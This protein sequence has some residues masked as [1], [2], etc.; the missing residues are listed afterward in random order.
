MN[1]LNSLSRLSFADPEKGDFQAVRAF[2]PGTGPAHS[3][4]AQEPRGTENANNEFSSYNDRIVI[5]A[6][7]QVNG[8][9]L[10][11]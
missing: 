10:S 7:F 9:S 8:L 11:H 6:E 3:L 5:H 4:L 2:E 1:A